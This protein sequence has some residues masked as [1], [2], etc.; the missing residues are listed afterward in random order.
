MVLAFHF[1]FSFILLNVCFQFTE[2]RQKAEEELHLK[3]IAEKNQ[4]ALYEQLEGQVNAHR[5]EISKMNAEAEQRMKKKDKKFEE[6]MHKRVMEER[7]LL[8]E[9]FAEKAEQLKQETVTL[10]ASHD[11]WNEA[12]MKKLAAY[13]NGV[14]ATIGWKIDSAIDSAFGMAKNAF[15]KLRSFF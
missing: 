8:E 14:F 5:Q 1:Q 4:Q 9:G 13:E 12:L 2:Q 6:L 11:E 7:R 10:R 3:E 15:T